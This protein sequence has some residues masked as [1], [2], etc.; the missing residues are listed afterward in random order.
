M[1]PLRIVGPYGAASTPATPTVASV[2]AVIVTTPEAL[3]EIVRGA[4]D[5]ALAEHAARSAMGPSPS[6]ASS[7]VRPSYT[8]REFA[9]RHGLPYR[10]VLRMVRSGELGSVASGESG[11]YVRI[12]WDHE[13]AWLRATCAK[14][15]P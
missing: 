1:K 5:A 15:R 12:R 14:V 10:E 3:A 6:S 4:V 8:R 13:A 11:R 2:P 7:P 9:E